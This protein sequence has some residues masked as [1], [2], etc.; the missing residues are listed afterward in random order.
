MVELEIVF[1][2]DVTKQEDVDDEQEGGMHRTLGYTLHQST[3]EGGTVIV[4]ELWPGPR[5]SNDGQVGLQMG[6]EN[7]VIVV[8][9]K[10][11]GRVEQGDDS[12]E[13]TVCGEE[14]DHPWLWEG[15]FQCCSVTRIQIELVKTEVGFEQG[16]NGTL[17]EILPN[18]KSHI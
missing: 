13:A 6:E 12:E 3:Y 1:T 9:D 11:G 8:V 7:G 17:V 5:E 15:L 4:R 14:D 10:G 16:S 18:W 2:Y